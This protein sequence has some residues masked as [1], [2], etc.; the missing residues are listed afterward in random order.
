MSLEL[1]GTDCEE[2]EDRATA[3]EA[4]EASVTGERF[5]TLFAG[6]SSSRTTRVLDDRNG[7]AWSVLQLL[8]RVFE[9]GSQSLAMQTPSLSVDPSGTDL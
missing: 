6:C 7:R 4:I 1:I 9:Q 5:I 2:S 3:R 8:A